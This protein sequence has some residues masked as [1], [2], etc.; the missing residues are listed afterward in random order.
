MAL[1][2]LFIE[3]YIDIGCMYEYCLW[4]LWI[5]GDCLIL[6]LTDWNKPSKN[7]AGGPTNICSTPPLKEQSYFN[8]G[9][10]AFNVF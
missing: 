2:C 5:W 3:W 9:Q 7:K 6:T 1:F 8:R 10:G 4:G